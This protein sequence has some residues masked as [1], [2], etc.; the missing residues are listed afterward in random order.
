MTIEISN[1]RQVGIAIFAYATDHQDILCAN[2][3]YPYDHTYLRRRLYSSYLRPTMG[4]DDTSEVWGCPLS[5]KFT[6]ST[7]CRYGNTW[8]YNVGNKG[9]M[10]ID[11]QYLSSLRIGPGYSVDSYDCFADGRGF[12]W[13]SKEYAVPA[14]IV[15]ISDAGFYKWYMYEASST[16]P[17]MGS[18][19]H[20]TMAYN[21]P[22]TTSASLALDGHALQRSTEQLNRFSGW[23]SSDGNGYR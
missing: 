8:Y 21:E 23:A 19:H 9:A 2:N 17:I 5:D 22:G 18:V 14:D 6:T 20:P 7:K 12:Y 10:T 15:I 4:T 16:T 3:A 13:G 1:M 11:G